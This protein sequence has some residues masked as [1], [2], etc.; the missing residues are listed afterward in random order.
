MT[1][2]DLRTLTQQ[3]P[4]AGRVDAIFLRPQRGAAPVSVASASAIVAR[5]LDG[6]R[7]AA[8]PASTAEGHKRQVTL[9]QA[10][11]LPL[12]AVWLAR[13]VTA[14]VRHA[15]LVSV[16]DAVQVGA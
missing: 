7:S 8:R 1:T 13:K 9:I 11:H 4:L 2:L 3:F 14:R 5:G 10:E 16:G 15:G 6:D 12:I